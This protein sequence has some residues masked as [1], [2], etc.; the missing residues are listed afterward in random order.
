MQCLHENEMV[1]GQLDIEGKSNEIAAIPLLLDGIDV[2]G[3]IVTIDAMGGN[4]RK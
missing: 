4:G 1:L 3:G 2:Q